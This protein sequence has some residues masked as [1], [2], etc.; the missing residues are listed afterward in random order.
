MRHIEVR[1]ITM[2]DLPWSSNLQPLSGEVMSHSSVITDD[3]ACLDVAMTLYCFGGSQFLNSLQV[4]LCFTKS[5][6]HVD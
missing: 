1:D 5:I 2:R 4:E 6:H 3:G